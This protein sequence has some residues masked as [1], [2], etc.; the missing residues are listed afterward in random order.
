MVAEEREEGVHHERGAVR[1]AAGGQ[2]ESGVHSE[3]AQQL[4]GEKAREVRS[5]LLPVE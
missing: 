1:A 2:Q 5:V 4:P 3:G